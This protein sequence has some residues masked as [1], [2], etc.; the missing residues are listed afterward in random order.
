MNHDDSCIKGQ[1]EL[2]KAVH[3]YSDVKIG[4]Q[5]AHNG[6]LAAHPKYKPVAPSPIIYQVTKQI[7]RELKIS[8]IEELVKK[9]ALAGRRAYECGYDLIQLHAAHGY[10]LISFL[11]PYTNKRTD[12]YGGNI[13]NRVRILIEIYTALRDEIGKNFPIIIKLQV[14]DGIE[15][16]LTI[17]ES[18]KIANLL[19]A[20]GLATGLVN[21]FGLANVFSVDPVNFFYIMHII[22]V[23][24]RASA[25]IILYLA[26]NK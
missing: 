24:F 25:G 12:N 18:T 16:G 17:E 2:V 4:S 9:F 14:E 19:V 8:E 15:G 10:L 26:Y 22:S 20:T 11:S 13:E 1:K 3:E 5:L 6:R 23:G 7:P 21:K